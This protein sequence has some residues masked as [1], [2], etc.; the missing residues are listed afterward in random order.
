MSKTEIKELAQRII[1]KHEPTYIKVKKLEVRED[2]AAAFLI[3]KVEDTFDL[4]FKF[5]DGILSKVGEYDEWAS[6]QLGPLTAGIIQNHPIKD[7]V[8]ELEN[9]LTTE[10]EEH[11]A[12]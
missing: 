10:L 7:I 2:L 12:G 8:N 9:E 3:C 4:T 5:E 11:Y 1:N 6:D